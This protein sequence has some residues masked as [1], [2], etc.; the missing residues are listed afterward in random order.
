MY[1]AGIV[2]LCYKI[3]NDSF[4]KR[5]K[6]MPKVS[7]IIPAYN[8]DKWLE[9]T[10]NSVLAQTLDDYELI[11]VDD[12]STDNTSG[13]VQ[14]VDDAR[15]R[16]F[17]KTNGGVCSARNLGLGKA[18]GEYIAFLDHDDMWAK[19]YLEVMTS[20]LEVNRDFGV[21]YA[22]IMQIR[23]DG[24]YC[25]LDRDKYCVSGWITSDLFIKLFVIPPA[26]V[27]KR[28]AMVGCYFDESLRVAEDYDFFLRL[29]LQ[30][31]FLFVRDTQL[32]RRVRAD[33]LSAEKILSGLHV[34][35]IRVLERFF[36]DL[37]GNNHILKR[38]ALG[39]IS[40]CYSRAGNFH[41]TFGAR[42]ASIYLF[43]K[44]LL[45]NPW[46]SKTYVKL[47]RSVLKKKSSDKMPNWQMPAP[48]QSVKYNI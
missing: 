11:V 18:C 6:P 16:Y 13:I 24:R 39:R 44:A 25:K 47:F 22:P 28:E 23:P 7:V 12:G 2:G 45:Y 27:I 4:E 31:K 19:D 32:I 40:R 38:K 33:G 14:N 10:I 1:G 37:G 43:K 46:A 29:S 20:A 42:K 36:Y 9:E 30:T 48:L 3:L 21:A 17:Y 5:M 41:Y 8:S 15:I 34:N 26:T 35:K